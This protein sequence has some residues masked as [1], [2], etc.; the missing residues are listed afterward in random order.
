[1]FPC[2][3]L[4]DYLKASL[5]LESRVR[6]GL[7]QNEA[8][9]VLLVDDSRDDALLLELELKRAGLT[10]PCHWLDNGE[11][12]IR[13]LA[14][15]GRFADRD[16]FPLPTVLLLDLNMPRV[17]GFQVLRWI[18]TRPELKQLLVIVVSALDDMKNIN[19]AY[20]LGA[21][22]YLTKP[23]NPDE[24]RNM[25]DFFRGYWTLGQTSSED[26]SAFSG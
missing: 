24:L 20:E 7:P 4:P 19:L 15:E 12:A 22:S 25:V 5:L 8:R 1:V 11:E 26:R 14:G 13:Y 21:K 3:E 2:Q 16:R 9:T 23:T 17:N 6:M 18:R 10:N